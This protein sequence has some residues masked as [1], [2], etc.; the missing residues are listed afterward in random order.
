LNRPSFETVPVVLAGRF[1]RIEALS[2]K[3][4]RDLFDAGKDADIWR[5]M[6]IP[7]FSDLDD[8]KRWIEESQ[9]RAAGGSEIAF[10]IIDVARNQAVGS[11]RYIDIRREHRGL[12]IGYT[13]LGAAA[14]RTSINTEC[15]WLLLK[16]AF[17]ELGAMRVQLKTDSR[18]VRSQKAIE[19]IGGIRE[20]VLRNH[21]HC[22]DG[23]IRDTVMYS[24]TD[25]EWPD[26][27]TRLESKI[28]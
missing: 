28:A 26:V 16:H 3:H 15:K 24:V 18:N 21:M 2:V 17:E 5:Y 1:V 4:A 25:K 23:S 6:P 12:E 14:Q 7:G 22:W 13:W 10:A 9:T 20:G 8:V 11:S 27:K 19:R